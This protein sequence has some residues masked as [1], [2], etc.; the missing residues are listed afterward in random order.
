MRE[1]ERRT[2]VDID[3]PFTTPYSR[4]CVNEP[5]I[6]G[7]R[8]KDRPLIARYERSIIIELVGRSPA[9][10]AASEPR[11]GSPSSGSRVGRDGGAG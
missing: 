1:I 5:F 9:G 3:I 11:V 4:D 6:R 8:V 10:S 7:N 2:G